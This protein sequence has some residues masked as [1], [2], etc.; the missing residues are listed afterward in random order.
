MASTSHVRWRRTLIGLTCSAVAATGL[1]GWSLGR[2]S[3]APAPPQV[4]VLVGAAGRGFQVTF[5]SLDDEVTIRARAANAVWIYRGDI[6]MIVCPGPA[7]VAR[8]GGFDLTL[9]FTTPGRHRV[10]AVAGPRTFTPTGTLD[11]DVLG[12]R[13]LGARLDLAVIDVLEPR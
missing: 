8:S 4:E 11:A 9:R 5:A 13:A 1:A 10:V 6:L 7:C 12:A 2:R 3:R